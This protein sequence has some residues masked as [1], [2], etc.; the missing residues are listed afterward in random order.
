MTFGFI[1]QLDNLYYESFSK[2]MVL[3]LNFYLFKSSYNLKIYKKLNE[4]FNTNMQ[5]QSKLLKDCFFYYNFNSLMNRVIE[6]PCFSL[7]L[8]YPLKKTNLLNKKVFSKNT[9]T[10]SSFWFRE[11][12]PSTQEK[13]PAV[14]ALASTPT[15]S[16]LTQAKVSS[17]LLSPFSRGIRTQAKVSLFDG[18]QEAYEA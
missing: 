13:R 11:A 12:A 7:N 3:M 4:K 16:G 17:P 5:Y 6:R 15:P 8:I 9:K 18:S 14:L 10:F 1:S 2:N